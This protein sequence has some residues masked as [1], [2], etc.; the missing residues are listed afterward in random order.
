M[1]GR[2]SDYYLLSR[3]FFILTQ[4]RQVRPLLF[5]KK[6]RM[7]YIISLILLK[8][9]FFYDFSI[10]HP[11]RRTIFYTFFIVLFF[12]IRLL[13]SYNSENRINYRSNIR[14]SCVF[15]SRLFFLNTIPH[16]SFGFFIFLIFLLKTQPLKILYHRLCSA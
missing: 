8:L 5:T 10:R 15:F 14:A 16:F 7:F 6:V 9:T 12:T 2:Y 11:C 3:Y 1:A 4:G 13:L